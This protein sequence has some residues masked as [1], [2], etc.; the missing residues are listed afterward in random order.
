MYADGRGLVAD[1][2]LDGGLRTADGEDVEIPIL[3]N[4]R[5]DEHGKDDDV[6]I[7]IVPARGERTG[8][9]RR[10]RSCWDRPL[11][12][13]GTDDGVEIVIVPARRPDKKGRTA[14]VTC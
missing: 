4:R 1:G 10:S 5:P 14:D 11:R 12:R 13:T 9:L 2:S 8:T 6:E 3:P 7:E